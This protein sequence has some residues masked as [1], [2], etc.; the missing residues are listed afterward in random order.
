MAMRN[1]FCYDIHLKDD[2]NQLTSVLL[3]NTDTPINNKDISTLIAQ[4]ALLD[5]GSFLYKL[6]QITHSQIEGFIIGVK[7]R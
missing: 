6:E 2:L 4:Q 5:A 7:E 3:I 1:F